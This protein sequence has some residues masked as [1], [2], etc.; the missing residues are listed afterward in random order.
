MP[1]DSLI[2]T[3]DVTLSMRCKLDVGPKYRNRPARSLLSCLFPP[4]SRTII[5]SDLDDVSDAEGCGDVS[6]VAGVGLIETASGDP[7]LSGSNDGKSKMVA[8]SVSPLLPLLLPMRQNLR[9]SSSS[10]LSRAFSAWS[11]SMRLRVWVRRRSSKQGV[12]HSRSSL[13]QRLHLDSPGG[14]GWH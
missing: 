4:Q 8:S 14:P 1:D 9:C 6:V 10:A 11:D 2:N 12:R 13:E 7:L 5:L 3:D